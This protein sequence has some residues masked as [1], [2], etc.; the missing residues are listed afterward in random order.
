MIRSRYSNFSRWWPRSFSGFGSRSMLLSISG[1]RHWPR[2]WSG[3]RT[4]SWSSSSS[5]ANSRS[6]SGAGKNGFIRVISGNK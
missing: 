1:K 5:G 2:S 4:D 6:W 3:A